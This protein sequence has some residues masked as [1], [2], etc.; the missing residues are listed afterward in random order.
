MNG[1]HP[2]SATLDA[3]PFVVNNFIFATNTANVGFYK[4]RASSYQVCI[5]RSQQDS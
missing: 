5:V 4:P 1:K 2:H 3:K